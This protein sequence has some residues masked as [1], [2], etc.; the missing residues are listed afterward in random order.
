[1]NELYLGSR[2]FVHLC[3]NTHMKHIIFSKNS[4]IY[5]WV[6]TQT[7]LPGHS[8]NI[9]G[10]K[11]NQMRRTEHDIYRASCDQLSPLFATE[12]VPYSCLGELG[13]LSILV[14]N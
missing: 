5:V 4:S 11:P 3:A 8:K 6:N 1:M 13:A 9:G 2:Y 10:L 14:S 7:D 12:S